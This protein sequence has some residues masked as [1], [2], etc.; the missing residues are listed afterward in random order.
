MIVKNGNIIAIGPVEHDD[1]LSGTGIALSGGRLGL[2]KDYATKEWVKDQ[3][4]LTSASVDITREWVEE[5]YYNKVD[6]DNTVSGISAWAS[7]TFALSANTYTKEEVDKMIAE[8]GGFEIVDGN[9]DGPYL[10]ATEANPKII[11]LVEISDPGKKDNY[12]EWIV[13]A[14]KPEMEWTCIGE[15]SIDL[16][17]YAKIGYVDDKVSEL[18]GA[19]DNVID[20][21][22]EQF[23]DT[24]AW[25][26]A[27]F[28]TKQDTYTKEEVD[29]KI[30]DIDLSDY[31]KTSYVDVKDSEISAWADD[32]FAKKTDVYTKDETYNKEEVD[33]KLA[34]LGGFEIVDGNEDG[35]YLPVDQAKT[36]IIYLVQDTAQYK[37][38][39]SEWI[40]TEKDGI[41]VW[42]CIGE[43]TLDVSGYAT[44]TYV[45]QKDTELSGAIDNVI[46]T[47]ADQFIDTSAWIK[48]EF[49]SH[50]EA[51]DWDIVEYSGADGIK[52]EDHVISLSADTILSA[53]KGINI[54][55]YDE[56]TVISLTPNQLELVGTSGI[57]VKPHPNVKGKEGYLYIGLSGNV[58]TSADLDA[59]ITDEEFAASANTWDIKGYSA[60]TGIDITDHIISVTGGGN[61]PLVGKDGI[62]VDD[63]DEDNTYIGI[64]ANYL[65]A[66][67]LDSYSA[68]WDTVTGKLDTSA[69][70]DVS[71]TFLTAHQSLADYY[72]KDETSGNLELQNAFDEKQDILIFEYDEDNAISAINSSAI[73]GQKLIAGIDLAIDGNVIKVNTGGAVANSADMS[74]VAGSATY[75]SG[76]GAVAIGLSAVASGQAAHAEGSHTSAIGNNAH[77]E[78]YNTSANGTAAHAEGYNTS[79]LGSYVHAE[80]KET[81]AVALASH[82]EG[83]RTF[84][85]APAAHAEGTQTSAVGNNSHSEGYKTVAVGTNSH[86]EGSETTAA[87][88]ECH[89]EGYGTIASGSESHAEG[90]MTSAFG[91]YSHTEGKGTIADTEGMH[92]GGKYNATSA[93]A[94]FVIGNGTDDEHRSDAFIVTTGGDI[95]IQNSLTVS[96]VDVLSAINDQAEVFGVSGIAIENKPDGVYFGISAEFASSADLTAYQ[97]ITGMSDYQTI[98]DMSAYI[99]TAASAG[100]D[101]TD[102]IG[103]SGI[104]VIDHVISISA[105]Q[106]DVY[107]ENGITIEKRNNDIYIGISGYYTSA[108]TETAIDTKIANFG[109]YEVVAG[110]SAGPTMD[111]S[112]ANNKFIYLVDEGIQG[113]DTYSEWI[114]TGTA[115]SEAWTCVGDT[116]ISLSDYATTAELD[117]AIDDI[118][119]AV[120]SDYVTTAVAENWDVMSYTAG[121]GITIEDHVIAV[122]GGSDLNLSAGQGIDITPSG[123]YTVISVS[124]NY[125]TDDDLT[126]YYDKDEVDALLEPYQDEFADMSAWALDTFQQASAMTG[127]ATSTQVQELQN[128][129]TSANNRINELESI[130]S[131]YSAR[132]VLLQ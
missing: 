103:A 107:G 116:S 2:A 88:I 130:I 35:P 66:D 15:T 131:A 95:T 109:G 89:T 4:Y 104:Q 98:A 77:S 119:A 38:N 83:E 91:L 122:T 51:N 82:A 120:S 65:S 96:G 102:Y 49:V 61:K 79:A 62:Y 3:H 84:A 111:A 1:T 117:N 30:A 106:S 28:A 94:L 46:D 56:T 118:S 113:K 73:A 14:G 5:N 71:G 33:N 16:G 47:V 121:N 34:N 108:E 59:Y 75:A 20:T 92:V 55:T 21:V 39:Y 64:S 69:F 114:V 29:E 132:W 93:D 105:E 70:S 48:D 68:T 124:D 57:F 43:T 8:F 53:G 36:N 23:M 86:A 22:A 100:W 128:Q 44:K 112:A 87:S 110:T 67:A 123:D 97:P 90:Y 125:V 127:Y 17:D 45:D 58:V 129:L 31:A 9:E 115:G 11:Y 10:P 41:K 85:V 26:S 52:V 6:I 37:D 126:A 32:T 40:V 63:G 74:F 25:A 50:D 99:P 24:S 76:I 12:A 60:G 72:T 101:V 80:G 54:D 13:P 7:D 27:T 78:G 81:F 18:S 42:T 19:I